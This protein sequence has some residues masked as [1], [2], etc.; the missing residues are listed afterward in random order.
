MIK[1]ENIKVSKEEELQAYLFVHFTNE[2]SENSEQIYFAE[3]KDGMRWESLNNLRPILMS[4]LGE[5]GLRDPH[6][7]SSSEVIS[8]L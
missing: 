1:N 8:F 7:I 6:T 4:K 2:V 5:S 3:S